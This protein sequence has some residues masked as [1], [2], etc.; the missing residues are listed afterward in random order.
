MRKWP[1]VH[2]RF[3]L[4]VVMEII[5]KYDA[6]ATQI[7]EAPDSEA[8]ALAEALHEAYNFVAHEL[9][10]E[11]PA[12][13]EEVLRWRTYQ[14]GHAGHVAPAQQEAEKPQPVVVYEAV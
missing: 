1:D 14:M 10:R 4:D 3:D 5:G 2:A 8:V 9:A 12:L 6:I 7:K 11:V 13:L